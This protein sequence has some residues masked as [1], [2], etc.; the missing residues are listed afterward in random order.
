M[1]G[2]S[3]APA[4]LASFAMLLRNNGTLRGHARSATAEPRPMSNAL[5]HESTMMELSPKTEPVA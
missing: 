3:L 4:G 2:T 5:P 1:D